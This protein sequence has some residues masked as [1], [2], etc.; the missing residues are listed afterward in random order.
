MTPDLESLLAARENPVRLWWRDDDAGRDDPRLGRL[1]AIAER[2]QAPLA[3]AVVP[4][5]LQPAA[6]D[7]IGAARDVTVLQ[8]GIAHQDHAA[9]GE[10]RIEMGGTATPA[11]LAPAIVDGRARLAA[12]FGER[13][14]SVMVPPWNRIGASFAAQLPAWGFGGLSTWA[15]TGPAA[16]AGLA[17]IDTH[18]DAVSW[19]EGRRCLGFAE[20][21][22]LLAGLL[23]RRSPEPLGLLTHHLVVDAAGFVALDRLIGLVQ[24]H[25]KLRIESASDLFREA[26]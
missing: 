25:P 2:H 4:D 24:D 7:R 10:R 26:A 3:L 16:P 23:R 14:R 6:A 18:L 11:G 13:F 19:R 12:I 21:T 17:C 1:I 5:W 20:L 15:G 22:E 8:H 9:P